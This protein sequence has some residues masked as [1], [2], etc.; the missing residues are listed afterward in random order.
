M[1]LPHITHKQ[2]E[3]LLLVPKF[4]FL[5]RTQIQQFLHHK[6]PKRINDWLRDLKEKQYL[7]WI[8]S[9]AFEKKS[10]PAIYYTGINTIRFLKATGSYPSSFLRKL[11]REK[12]R[13]DNFISQCRLI[14]DCCLSFKNQNKDGVSYE[15]F[16]S[17]YFENSSFPFY[18]L[19]SLCPHLIII[20]KEM[21]ENKT[22]KKYFILEVFEPTLPRYSIRKKLRNYLDFY[23]ANEWENHIEK[24]FPILL[25]ICPD[26]PFLI[27]TKRFVKSLIDDN[28]NPKDLH[29]RFATAGDVKKS[30]ANAGIWEEA[31]KRYN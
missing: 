9:T 1:T 27:Y 15:V 16:T 20:K 2:Q 23:F 18:F 28:Q 30:G 29:V 19:K 6:Y 3:I 5:D 11:Y 4:R 24:Q 22:V 7:E 12:D 14:A 13:S 31:G 26:K 17:S 10:K 8:Y 21:K 25:F